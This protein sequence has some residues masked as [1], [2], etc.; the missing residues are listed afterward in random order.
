MPSTNSK[1]YNL[2]HE[3]QINHLNAENG[4][5][6]SR[7]EMTN[8]QLRELSCVYNSTNSHCFPV[9]LIVSLMS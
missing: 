7:A 9:F 4:V 1:T 2:W 6:L 8:E 5:A 3:S